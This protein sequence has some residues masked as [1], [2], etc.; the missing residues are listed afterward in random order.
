MVSPKFPTFLS[1]A[2]IRSLHGLIDRGNATVQAFQRPEP[3]V[4]I[5]RFDHETGRYADLGEIRLIRLAF[6]LREQVN[7]GTDT[8]IQRSFADGDM[9]MWADDP[10]VQ[11]SD[12]FTFEGHKCEITAVYPPN[13]GTVTCEVRLTQ[14]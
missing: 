3:T 1:E 7:T 2:Q 5:R 8:P 10:P 9:K 12:R 11:V 6:G 14:E 13:Q 4:M